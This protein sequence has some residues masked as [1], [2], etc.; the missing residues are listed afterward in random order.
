MKLTARHGATVLALIFATACDASHEDVAADKAALADD[1]QATGKADH[2]DICA[3]WDWYDDDFCDDP[4]GWCAQ[5]DPDCGPD[6]DSC[7]EG[8]TWSGLASEGCVEA[9]ASEPATFSEPQIVGQRPST[10]FS[11]NG[12]ASVAVDNQGGVHLVYPDFVRRV[13]YVSP[14]DNWEPHILDNSLAAYR[15]LTIAAD[16]S[17]HVAVIDSDYDLN[18]LLLDGATIADREVLPTFA[19]T[20]GMALGAEETHLVYGAGELT[21]SVGSSS[22]TLG[23]MTAAS[24]VALTNIDEARNAP[25]VTVDES[26]VIHA[27]YGTSP[28]AYNLSSSAQ[29]RHAWRAPSGTWQDEFLD[30]ATW[31]GGAITVQSDGNLFAA[32]RAF[33]DGAQTLMIAEHDGSAWQTQPLFGA[34]VQGSAA[35]TITSADGTVHVVYWQSGGIEHVERRPGGAW[36]EPTVLDSSASMI[37]SDRIS[38]ALGPD[39]SVHVA[40]SDIQSREVRYVSRP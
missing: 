1:T 38:I 18:Y 21:S 7:A 40:Y 30:R 22:G 37:S 20:V 35:N 33:V 16:E 26:G 5:P 12:W 28:V 2:L 3:G 10:S 31:E 23:S 13:T 15:G 9:E 29:I 32:Y 19:R 8:W 27:V 4:Y 36:T 17:V 25:S 6:G 34:G 14:E 24:V 39:D 11:M